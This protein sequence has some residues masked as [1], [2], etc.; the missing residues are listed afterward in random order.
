M[1][2]RLFLSRLGWLLAIVAVAGALW[3]APVHAG[4]LDFSF[5]AAPATLL[6]VTAGLGSAAALPAL[7]PGASP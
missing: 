2:A 3:T 1:R 5:T 6:L 4:T 7:G